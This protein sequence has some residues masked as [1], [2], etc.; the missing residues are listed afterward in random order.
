[1]T[2]PNSASGV[3]GL[4]MQKAPVKALCAFL[5]FLLYLPEVLMNPLLEA[6]YWFAWLPPLIVKPPLLPLYGLYP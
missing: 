5:I 4:N 2:I 6:P 1:M 3:A